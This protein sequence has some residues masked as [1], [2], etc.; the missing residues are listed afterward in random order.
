MLELRLELANA[1][2]KKTMKSARG[3]LRTL[4]SFQGEYEAKLKI[5]KIPSQKQQPPKILNVG[6][7]TELLAT[8]IRC[9]LPLVELLKAKPEL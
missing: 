7:L 8:P 9:T 5:K 4:P 6:N 1:A 2:S 3:T